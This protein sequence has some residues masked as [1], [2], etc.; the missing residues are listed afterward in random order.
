MKEK[1]ILFVC[2]GN[3]CRSPA[4]EGV[5]SSFIKSEGLDELIFVDSAGTLSYHQGE[6]ADPRMKAHA[7]KRGYDL[8]SISRKFNPQKD[9]NEFDYIVTMDN[10]NFKEIKKLAANSEQKSKIFKMAHFIKNHKV[11]E[12]PD[13]YY[14]GPEGFE[15][16]LDIIEDGCKELL[17]K[18]KDEIKQSDKIRN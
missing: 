1:K 3:I 17:E 13:P 14:E 8:T 12:V 15:Y 11:D 18:V 4:A 7:E 10:S 16:V 2:L 6:S 5:M 9:F